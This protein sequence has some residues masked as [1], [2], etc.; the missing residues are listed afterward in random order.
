[1]ISS[2]LTVMDMRS[3]QHFLQGRECCASLPQW[4]IHR[5]RTIGAI[6]RMQR[7]LSEI[8]LDRGEMQNDIAIKSLI[9]TMEF[10]LVNWP[11]NR[12]NKGKLTC[13]LAFDNRNT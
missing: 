2:G 8:D 6:S 3:A 4:L 11:M 10:E 9:T 13:S 5:G 12:N 7:A 1:M